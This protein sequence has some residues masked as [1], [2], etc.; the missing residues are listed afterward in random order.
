MDRF[1]TPFVSARLEETP[2]YEFTVS[3]EGDPPERHTT[4]DY[5]VVI[6]LAN[7]DEWE[8]EHGF[9]A[10][11]DRDGV[12]HS[13]AEAFLARVEGYGVAYLNHWRPAQDHWAAYR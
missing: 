10:Y 5:F 1:A 3:W 8:H 11:R 9:R 6:T 12:D 4:F 13:G 7:G 2:F